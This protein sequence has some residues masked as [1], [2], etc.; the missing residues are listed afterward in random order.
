MDENGKVAALQIDCLKRHVGSCT[1]LDSIPEHL[2]RDIYIYPAHNI[3]NG[4]LDI[5]PMR[6]NRWIVVD[7]ERIKDFF[8]VVILIDSEKIYNELIIG[9]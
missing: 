6:N 8:E 3:I 4:P 9:E 7:Y 1:I 2:P 5:V